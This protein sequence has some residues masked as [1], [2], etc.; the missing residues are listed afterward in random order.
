MNKDQTDHIFVIEASGL[1]GLILEGKNKIPA[2]AGEIL[3]IPV[4]ISIDPED[5]PSSTNSIEFKIHSEDD[6]SIH[7]TAESR[8]LGPT[9]R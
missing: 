7:R 5:I 6:P 1:N 4:S 8:F 9:F 3:S 2:A